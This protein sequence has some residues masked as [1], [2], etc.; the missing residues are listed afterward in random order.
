MNTHLV[1]V[2]TDRFAAIVPA[3][4]TLN[5]R[6][7]LAIANA[8][9]TGRQVEIALDVFRDLLSTEKRHEFDCLTWLETAAVLNDWSS[10]IQNA[11]TEPLNDERRREERDTRKWRGIAIG[12]MIATAVVATLCLIP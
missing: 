12:M 1:E 8:P 4:D 2:R 3:L 11:Y 7:V 9:S 10:K 6:I 5:P